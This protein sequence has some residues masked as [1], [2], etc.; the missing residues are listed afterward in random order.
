M[1]E[2]INQPSRKPT[3]KI[4]LAAAVGAP[5]SAAVYALLY[6]SG[7]EIP[8]V[9]AAPMGA[10]LAALVGYWVRERAPGL[11]DRNYGR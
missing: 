9:I 1:S 7:I 4:E 10:L 11:L 2:L 3:R 5:L 8:E 6:M